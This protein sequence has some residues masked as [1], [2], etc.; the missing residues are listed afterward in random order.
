[1]KKEIVQ[2]SIIAKSSSV[3]CARVII[4]PK[5]NA[6]ILRF[7]CHF[8]GTSIMTPLPLLKHATKEAKGNL[9]SI[10]K[11]ADIHETV[12][13]MHALQDIQLKHFKN[14]MNFILIK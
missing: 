3:Q 10:L 2:W 1:M 11:S 8:L 6:W 5:V 9:H 12:I 4:W 13:F 14:F 7:A